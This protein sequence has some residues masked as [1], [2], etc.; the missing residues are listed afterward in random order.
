[1]AVVRKNFTAMTS[2]EKTAFANALRQFKTT[3]ANGRNYN[4]YI[5]QHITFF[6]RT[7]DNI[8]HAHQSPSFF[9]WHR[10]YLRLLELDLQTVSG[11]PGIFIPY[12]DWTVSTLPFTSD[13]LGSVTNGSVSS[14]N[15][16]PAWGWSLYRSSIATSF[17]QRRVGQNATRPTASQ[18]STVQSRTVY[19][20]SPWNSTVSNSYRNRNEI[21]LHNRVHNYVGGHM[22]TR[23]APNDPCFWLHHCNID[24]LWWLWQTV[25]GLDTYQPRT[26]TTSGVVDNNETM[27][28]FGAGRSPLAVHDISAL[29]Y[30]Y[31]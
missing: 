21:E 17:L 29:N 25:R 30:S 10:E 1:M 2:A 6:A 8:S 4:W 24:R 26:G 31:A 3:S 19:D 12:W 22:G 20:Q 23:E 16:S 13:F 7:T 9:P 11:N 27:R 28:P 5:D 15:F 18:V 14:G